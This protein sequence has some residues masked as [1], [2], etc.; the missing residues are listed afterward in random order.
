MRVGVQDLFVSK[1]GCKNCLLISKG[2]C[3]GPVDM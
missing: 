3:L 1:G 2:D